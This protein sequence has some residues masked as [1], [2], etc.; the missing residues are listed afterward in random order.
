MDQPQSMAGLPLMTAELPGTGGALK[1]QPAHFVVEELPL[2]APAGSGA[3]LYVNLTRE[4]MA[5]RQ[6]VH[7]LADLFGLEEGAV[8]YAGLKDKEARV[9]QTFSLADAALDPDE[10]ARR[11][12]GWLPVT[13]HWA[14]R[15]AN[16]LKPGHLMGNRFTLVVSDPEPGA[17]E[18]ARAIARALAERGA[19]NFFGEQRFG[20]TGDNAVAGRE[21]LAGRRGPREKWKRKLLLSAWQSELFN[22][23]LA[24][25]IGDGLFRRILEGDVAKK[26]DTGGL[27]TVEDPA[28][29]QP[30]LD[31]GGIV[32]TGPLFGAK[33]RWATGPAGERE[34]AAL[35]AEGVEESALKK[36]GLTGSRRPAIMLVDGLTVDEHPDGLAFGFSLPKG[37]Y[38]TTLMREF[39]KG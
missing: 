4:G 19:A 10:A 21:L 9:T 39:M 26:T 25:R 7:E 22:R 35:A 18:R 11:I 14:A 3:H 32:Y 12:Q 16:K 2:Y 8:G 28:A 1:A 34:R 29:E 24:A 33:M 38:A 37:S 5:T 13:V 6:V 23:W 30:R 36:A 27:F 20:A 31:G 17:L 15:H